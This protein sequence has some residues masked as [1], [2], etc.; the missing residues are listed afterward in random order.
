MNKIKSC[1]NC[2]TKEGKL[3]KCSGC[4]VVDYCSVDC[5]RIHWSQ[6]KN[7]CKEL[8]VKHTQPLHKHTELI[9][10]TS[11]LSLFLKVLIF[12]KSANLTTPHL[13]KIRIRETADYHRYY[14][15][16]SDYPNHHMIPPWNNE[17]EPVLMYMDGFVGDD[18]SGLFLIKKRSTEAFSKS[19]QSFLDECD[20]PAIIE[21]SG[22]TMKV[23]ISG[24]MV[25]LKT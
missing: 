13:T 8:A 21:V 9:G 6:H 25:I 16:T 19:S 22:D 14:I 7:S 3:R 5:Q 23:K 4:K 18:I 17:T 10:S 11:E 12:H 24:I 2:F 20:W 1:Y 15:C